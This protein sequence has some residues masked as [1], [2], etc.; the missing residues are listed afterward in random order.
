[1]NLGVG[2]YR[3][4]A[5]KPFVLSCVRKAEALIASK[6]LDKEYLGIGGLGEFSKSCAELALGSDSEVLSSKRSITV[7]T[8]SGTGSLR[9]GAN[10]LARFHTGSK[11]V[12]LPKPS[13]GNHT[14]ICRDAGMQLKAYRYY[15]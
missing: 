2:A 15:D 12:Y 14:P 6:Q 5:G 3:D 4:D 8:I 9:I 13:W 7:Q 1:M 10:F 11:D